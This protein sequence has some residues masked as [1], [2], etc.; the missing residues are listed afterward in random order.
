MGDEST[1]R[2]ARNASWS[3]ATQRTITSHEKVRMVDRD[4]RL[5]LH[6][7]ACRFGR[8][9]ARASPAS[10]RAGSDV[11]RCHS[12]QRSCESMGLLHRCLAGGFWDLVAMFGSPL[13]AYLIAEPGRPDLILQ[14]LAWPANLAVVVGSII[15]YR[16]LS[17]KPPRD[18]G[19]F[20]LVF[21]ATT[22]LLV[23]ATALLAPT[24][25]SHLAGILHPRWPWTR[26]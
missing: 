18:A 24:Y 14:G 5:V 9:R 12:P 25:V 8:L 23:G 22:A 21:L 26:S 13:F 17:V 2:S 19:S 15:G 16:R 11:R 10:R 7:V 6:P 4:W 1:G 3:S 20:A